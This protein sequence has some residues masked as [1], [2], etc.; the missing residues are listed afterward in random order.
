MAREASLISSRAAAKRDD[1]ADATDW[2]DS[3]HLGPNKARTKETQAT[4]KQ[5]QLASSNVQTLPD[6]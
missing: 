5:E 2:F 4:A 6:L 3:R 1:V